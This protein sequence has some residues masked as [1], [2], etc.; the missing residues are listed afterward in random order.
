MCLA[1]FLYVYRCSFV[2]KSI[3]VFMNIHIHFDLFIG[4]LEAHCRRAAQKWVEHQKIDSLIMLNV[5]HE[6][7]MFCEL[8]CRV[9]VWLKPS[10]C[11]PMNS[12]LD[13]IH[14]AIITNSLNIKSNK[15]DLHTKNRNLHLDAIIESKTYGKKMIYFFFWDVRSENSLNSFWIISQH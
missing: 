1:V 12:H 8:V 7:K 14:M 13:T 5:T 9:Y 6:I 3:T 2:K 4:R 10:C 15:R 11:Y